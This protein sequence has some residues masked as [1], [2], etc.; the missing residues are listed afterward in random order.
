MIAEAYI[1]RPAELAET[2]RLADV[3]RLVRGAGGPDQR[4]PIMDPNCCV[5]VAELEGTIVGWAKTHHHDE[6]SGPAPAGHYLGGVNVHPAFR[7]RGIGAALTQDRL[8]WISGRAPE[9]WF[10][11]NARN[12]VSVALHARFGFV[13]VS[14]AGEFHGTTFDG[15]VGILFHAVLVRR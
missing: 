11:T 14:R 3:S 1:I 8:E 12:S 2:D 7:R 9:A 5:I 4:G 6:A 15:G 10:F 13:E